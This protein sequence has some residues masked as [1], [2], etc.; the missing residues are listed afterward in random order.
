MARSCKILTKKLGHIL[1]FHSFALYHEICEYSSQGD[2]LTRD[3]VPSLPRQFYTDFTQNCLFD[4]VT[5]WGQFGISK[6]QK[7][8]KTYSDIASLISVPIEEPVLQATLRFWDPS[9]QCFTFGKEDL[10]PTIKE[11]SVLIGVD[12]QHP[13]KVYNRKPRSGYQSVGQD[14]EGQATN[15]RYLFGPEGGLSRLTVENFTGLHTGAP[16]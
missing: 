12:L 4:L 1:I 15:D 6:K 14:L 9:Y 16:T 10:V 5:L 7:F 13:D 3:Y 2:Y 8:R 11:Y